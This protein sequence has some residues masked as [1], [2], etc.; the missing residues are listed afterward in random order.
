MACHQ[1][2]YQI[3]AF[4]GKYRTEINYGLDSHY[5]EFNW[6]EISKVFGKWE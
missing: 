3:D 1:P 4:S 5:Q 6:I 2:C